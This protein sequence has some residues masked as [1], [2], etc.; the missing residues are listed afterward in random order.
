MSKEYT[1][2]LNFWEG[3]TVGT[4]AHGIFP[5][6]HKPR[7]SSIHECDWRAAQQ[8][9]FCKLSLEVCITT[10]ATI[11]TRSQFS[12]WGLFPGMPLTALQTSA[13]LSSR[14][15]T[16]KSALAQLTRIRKLCHTFQQNEIG[17]YRLEAQSNIQT[18][19]TSNAQ[20]QKKRDSLCPI[21]YHARSTPVQ[22]HSSQKPLAISPI[23][24]EWAT[25]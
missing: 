12:S 1:N 11:H 23:T 21:I 4:A 6:M 20:A 22:S 3:G 8:P 7:T 2:D 25:S 15:D 18:D 14:F 5:T 9:S 16:I 13:R 19:A 24:I 10:P 17:I